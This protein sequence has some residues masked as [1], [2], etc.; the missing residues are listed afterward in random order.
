MKKGIVALVVA[1]L[2]M[3][4][5]ITPA[6]A[7]SHREA[8]LIAN[9]PVADNTDVYFFRSPDASDTVTM[10]ANWVPF[11]DPAGGPNFYRFGDDVLYELHVFNN[12]DKKEDVTYQLR[13]KTK[14]LNTDTFL[15][16]TGPITSIKDKNFNIQQLYSL[17]E[18]KK[19]KK[20]V[21]GTDISTP[22]VNVGPKSTPN[23]EDLA[24]QAVFSCNGGIK[25]FAGQRDDPFFVDLGSVF[26]LLTIRG[27]VPAGF[28]S[29]GIDGLGGFNCQT[30]AIQVP[31]KRLTADGSM[32][33]DALNTN[34]VLGMYASAS[35]KEVKV[36]RSNGNIKGSGRFVQVSRLGEPLVNELLIPLGKKDFWNSQDVVNDKQF[37]KFYQDPEPAGL[38]KALFGLSVPDTPRNDI[39]AILLQGFSLKPLGTNFSNVGGPNNSDLIRL[40]VAVEPTQTPNRI[41]LIG[42]DLAGFPNG[43]RL[44]D[45]VVD[46]ELRALAGATP[47]TPT[48]N[49]SP[50]NLLG[51]GVNE[52]DKPFLSTFPYVATPHQGF[53]HKHHN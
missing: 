12:K 24:K 49:K 5:S 20:T 43:R 40:N 13:F 33:T 29:G 45:D 2:L 34:A 31:I 38:L 51:D 30:I 26:D 4:V 50:N 14:I 25:V 52:N 23:Y 21:L 27:G 9:D 16:N 36:L 42:G 11:E 18:I 17:T 19:G 41:G 44:Q 37:L 39:V 7:S 10:V 28:S 32:P 53:E 22:P 8:P 1:A 47:F 15:Y 6:L 46:I 48:F 3:T 35:R